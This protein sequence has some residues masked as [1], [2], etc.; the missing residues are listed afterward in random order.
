MG[1]VPFGETFDV[2]GLEFYVFQV[3]VIDIAFDVP[4]QACR[5]AEPFERRREVSQ[6]VH[7]HHARADVALEP[8]CIYE[9]GPGIRVL[10]RHFQVRDVNVRPVVYDAEIVDDGL[11]VADL[12]ASRHEVADESTFL[13]ERQSVAVSGH[14]ASFQP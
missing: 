11:A 2:R 5:H 6:C 3:Q 1:I 4:V 13:P 10:V 9:V 14:H 12:G 7:A 8:Y